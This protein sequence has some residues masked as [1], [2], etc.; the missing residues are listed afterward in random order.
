M[1]WAIA[2]APFWTLAALFFFAGSC[3][4]VKAYQAGPSDSEF[5][6]IMW[7]ITIAFTASGIIG[8]IAARLCS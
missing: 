1:I 8:Y 3:G 4:T 5:D 2:S 6:G 7:S